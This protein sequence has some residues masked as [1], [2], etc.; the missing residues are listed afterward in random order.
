MRNS[1]VDYLNSLPWF[2]VTATIVDGKRVI[3]T[4]TCDHWKVKERVCPTSFSYP[5]YS[6]N[7]AYYSNEVERWLIAVTGYKQVTTWSQ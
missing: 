2:K 6:R 5:E 7:E 4:V 1:L 3:I